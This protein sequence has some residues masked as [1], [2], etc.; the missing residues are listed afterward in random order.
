MPVNGPR[1]ERFDGDVPKDLHGITAAKLYIAQVV[2][3]QGYRHVVLLIRIPN[4]K[5][6]DKFLTFPQD[7]YK[8]MGVL[9]D[10]LE[11]KVRDLICPEE[12]KATKKRKKR[13]KVKQLTDDVVD[14]MEL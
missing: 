2:D 10:W 13:K 8:N 12:T 14:V 6:P 3:P 4:D 7:F 5:G 9:P 11:K 1:V